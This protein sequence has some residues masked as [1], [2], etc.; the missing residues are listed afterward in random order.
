MGVSDHS[1]GRGNQWLAT[2]VLIMIIQNTNL[3]NKKKIAWQTHAQD[4][5]SKVVLPAINLCLKD[6]F[7]TSFEEVI[8]F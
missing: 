4:K 7:F 8:F 1:P 2:K 6:N 3:K 5:N